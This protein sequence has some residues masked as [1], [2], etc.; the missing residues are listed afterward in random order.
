MKQIT[1]RMPTGLTYIERSVFMKQVDDQK[2]WQYDLGVEGSM[3]IPIWIIIGFQQ[4]NRKDS[5]NLSND[6]FCR[7]PV[8]SAKCVT[9]TENYPNEAILINHT[10]DNFNQGYGQFKEAFRALTKDNILQPYISDHDF[11]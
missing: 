4:Q 6:T 3:N 1:N 11:R 7:L 5:Q 9:N 8:V 2:E 10:D